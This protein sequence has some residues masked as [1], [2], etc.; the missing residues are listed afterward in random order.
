MW[1]RGE[2]FAVFALV[3]ATVAVAVAPGAIFSGGDQFDGPSPERIAQLE[4]QFRPYEDQFDQQID[5][6]AQVVVL[7]KQGAPVPEGHG[8]QIERVEVREGSHYL[9]GSIPYS[10]ITT[11]SADPRTETILIEHRPRLPA[12]ENRVATGVV[13]IGATDLHDQGVRGDNVTVG[14]VG[15]GFRVSSPEIADY[16]GAY[17]TF[18]TED[19]APAAD[20]HG[21]AVASIVA[22]TAPNAT[23]YLA[24]VGTETTAS[25]YD[26]AITWLLDSEVDIVLD[27]G[28]YFDE[29]TAESSI[30]DIAN[31]ASE[32][33]VF[34]TSAGNYAERHWQGNQSAADG[35]WVSFADGVEGNALAGGAPITG[36]VHLTLS[37]NTSDDY[38][39][40][41]LRETGAQ[42]TVVAKSTSRQTEGASSV[43]RL[44]V[45]VPQGQ[46]YVGIYGHQTTGNTSLDLF[47]SK[48]NLTYAT[49]EGSLAAPATAPSVLTVGSSDGRDVAAFSSRGPTAD[50]RNGVDLVA[51]GGVGGVDIAGVSAGTSV[52]A[53]YAAGSAALLKSAYPGLSAA[54]I[55]ALLTDSATD[56]GEEGV[57]SESGYGEVNVS[58]AY[59]RAKEKYEPRE[60]GIATGP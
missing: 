44:S 17:R 39:L 45:M 52:S 41:L 37:W 58:A 33:V 34:V 59:E 15:R 49:P 24:D 50:G 19:S 30:N 36:E 57:D 48:R 35:S 6:D 11:L 28:S 4:D 22:D 18:S 12:I 8:L 2:R 27:A 51:P 56:L 23:L 38:D 7:L 31:R 5:R 54:E 20:A 55:T 26:R 47:S 53:S 3:F 46:Y 9:H 60:T 40:Y 29:G 10:K 21:T 14:I 42:D 13:T 1:V 25:E 16:V 43:E 32:E